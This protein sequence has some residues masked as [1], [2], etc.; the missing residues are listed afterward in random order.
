MQ[1]SFTAYRKRAI[2]G[3]CHLAPKSIFW[4]EKTVLNA[5]NPMTYQIERNCPGTR[6][7]RF[8]VPP[9]VTQGH[10]GSPKVKYRKIFKIGQMAYQIEGNSTGNRMQQF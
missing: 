1:I 4:G 3:H 2:A 10:D 7:Q 8:L 6:M 5:T 9:D